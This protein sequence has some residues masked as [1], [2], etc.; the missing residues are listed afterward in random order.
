METTQD[1]DVFGYKFEGQRYDCGSKAGYLQATVAFALDRPELSDEFVD[2]LQD[3][4]ARR[5]AAK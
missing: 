4:L 5:A 2:Y 1:R 3:I